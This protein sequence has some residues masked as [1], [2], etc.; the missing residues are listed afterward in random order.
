MTR[1]Q[2]SNECQVVFIHRSRYNRGR[3]SELALMTS[4]RAEVNVRMYIHP[5]GRI[6][7]AFVCQV[8]D[9]ATLGTCPGSLNQ[10]KPRRHRILHCCRL[11]RLTVSQLTF[12]SSL[13]IARCPSCSGRCNRHRR[14]LI[15]SISKVSEVNSI[16]SGRAWGRISSDQSIMISSLL[17]SFARS[18]HGNTVSGQPDNQSSVQS[19]RQRSY[20]K[21]QTHNV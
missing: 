14:R 13:N 9:R 11:E 21:P 1:S 18:D 7:P 2:V 4:T 19:P 15:G 16:R 6:G 17:A 20:R 8:Q 3:P 5:L 12:S 10:G